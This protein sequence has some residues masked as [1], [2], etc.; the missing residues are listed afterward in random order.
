MMACLEYVGSDVCCNEPNAILTYNNFKQLEGVFNTESGGCDICTINLKRLWCEYACSPRQG[1]FLKVSSEYYEYPDPQNPG[2]TLI[3]QEA[4][5]TIEASTACALYS[6]CKRVPFV[7]SVSAL[8][9][10]A[11]FLNFQG[12]NA[13]NDARQYINVFFTYDQSKGLYF[14]DLNPENTTKGVT[15]CNFK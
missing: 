7:A 8:N 13:V 4:N 14:N 6:S 15:T 11:G 1:E 9:T 10:P 12:H 3:A 5:L 2:K